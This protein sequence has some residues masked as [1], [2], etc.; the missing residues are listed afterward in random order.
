MYFWVINTARM[1]NLKKKFLYTKMQYFCSIFWFYSIR[2]FFIQI[3]LKIGGEG[4]VCM[5]NATRGGAL[6]RKCWFGGKYCI[7]QYYVVLYV[8]CFKQ[9]L[10]MLIFSIEV[11][12]V[13]LKSLLQ[14]AILNFFC[15]CIFA[16]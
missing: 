3:M 1:S 12:M 8:F 10:F 2:C 11:V 15:C 6:L 13:T 14:I 9:L 5:P 4:Y 16:V 7:L